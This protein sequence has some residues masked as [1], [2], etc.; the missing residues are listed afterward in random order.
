MPAP[1]AFRLTP[2]H[3]MWRLLP[4]HQRRRLVTAGAALLAPRV[5]RHPPAAHTGVAVAGELSR[6]S[7]LG[8]NA[9]LMLMGLQHLGVPHWSVDVG[10]L[11]PGANADLP[12]PDTADPPPGVPIIL[13]VN[14]PLLP[15]VLLRLRRLTKR[16]R[17]VGYWYWELPVAPPEWRAGAQFVH[18]VWALSPFTADALAP[19]LPAPPRAVLP[20]LAVVPPR[21]SGLD[22]AAFGLPRDAVVVLVSFNLASS[23]ARKNPLAAITAFR[24]AFGDRQDRLLLLKIGN[25]SH[26]PDDFARI[27]AAAGAAPNIRLETRTFPTADAHALTAACDII[28]SLHRSE[29]FGLV[30]AEAMFLGKPV[31]ATGWS[32]NMA[33]MDDTCAALVRYRLIPAQDPRHVYE[34]ADWAEPDLDHAVAQLRRLADSAEARASLG[35][36]AKAA[37]SARLGPEPL[38]A[39]VRALGLPA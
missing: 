8:E 11:M 36:S 15:L 2:L 25:R 3:R 16:R 34:G 37:V 10:P 24:A 18:D 1:D 9:R 32:G 26:F 38:R 7:G 22:R 12:V 29:G 30:P 20:P 35:V 4:T 5:D 23:M 21:P 14:P 39:A 27:T 31:I 19:L 33:F 17:V 28:L 6:A 13:H